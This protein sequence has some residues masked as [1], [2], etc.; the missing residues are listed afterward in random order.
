MLCLSFDKNLGKILGDFLQT[1]L[2][3]LAEGNIRVRKKMNRFRNI[4]KLVVHQGDPIGRIFA[5]WAIAF[6]GQYFLIT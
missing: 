3:T 5:F 4:K 6:F 2:V 1:H